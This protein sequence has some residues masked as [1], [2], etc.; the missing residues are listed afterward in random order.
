[1]KQ[2]IPET[3]R[4]EIP[5]AAEGFSMNKKQKVT[6]LTER[7]RREYPVLDSFLEWQTPWQLVAAVAL[8]ARTTDAAVNRVTPVLFDKWPGLRELAAA[9]AREVEEVVHPLGFYKRKA[10]NLVGAARVL[11]N[12]FD[13]EVPVDMDDLLALPGIGRKSANVIRAHLWNLPGIIVDTHFSRVV[14]RLGLLKDNDG[15]MSAAAMEKQMLKIVP[16]GDMIDFSMGINYHGRKCCH[17]RK[18][19]CQRCVLRDLCPFPG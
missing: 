12:D 16:P 2:E 13:G 10:A 17:A 4:P 9:D 5:A 18:P 14:A 7:L 3:R 1:L 6:V 19:E 11:L 15:A 8:S